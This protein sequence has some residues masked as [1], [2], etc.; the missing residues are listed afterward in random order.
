M[1][2]SVVSSDHT[3]GSFAGNNLAATLET[4]EFDAGNGQRV[5][6]SG[7]RPVVDGGTA[8]AAVGTR[9]ATGEAVTYG[10][11]TAAEA[12]GVC[13]QR[14]SARYAR[15][16]V[17]IAADGSWTHALGIEPIVQPDGDR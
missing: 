3:L 4:G 2:L 13:P 16:R 12:D 15:A 8:T 5:F 9:D 11:A 1:V 7:I 17:Q 10:T 14:V 6:V